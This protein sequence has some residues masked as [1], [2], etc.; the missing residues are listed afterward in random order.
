MRKDQYFGGVSV[1]HCEKNIYI[2]MRR[3][4]NGYRDRVV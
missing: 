3:I 1:G 4:L 2:N